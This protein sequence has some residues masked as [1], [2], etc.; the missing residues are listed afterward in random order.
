M[1]NTSSATPNHDKRLVY[2]FSL[3]C[4]KRNNMMHIPSKAINL[5]PLSTVTKSHTETINLMSNWSPVHW[6]QRLINFCN[7]YET[8]RNIKVHNVTWLTLKQEFLHSLFLCKTISHLVI[9]QDSQ[10]IARCSSLCTHSELTQRFYY[11][12][13]KY[14][15]HIT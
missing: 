3:K 2:D 4:Y 11:W 5:P 7:I 14:V 9:I 12:G 13:I 1:W 15:P 8:T 10:Q 6:S